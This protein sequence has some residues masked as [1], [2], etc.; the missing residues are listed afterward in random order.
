MI[1]NNNVTL[2]NNDLIFLL[3]EHPKTEYPSFIATTFKDIYYTDDENN[4]I[5]MVATNIRLMADKYKQ[6]L[7][8]FALFQACIIKRPFNLFHRKNLYLRLAEV[9]REFGNKA[10]WDT[11][12]EIHFKSLSKKLTMQFF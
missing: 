5:D 10:T 4:W 3:T 11:P 8:Y 6:A 9:D 2:S 12:F 7:A 1:E